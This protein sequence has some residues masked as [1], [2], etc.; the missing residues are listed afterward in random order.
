MFKN[1]GAK[2]MTLSK[3][4][5]GIYAAVGVL[6]AIAGGV[7]V[8]GIGGFFVF[9]FGAAV[10]VFVAWLSTILLYALGELCENI[11]AMREGMGY[12]APEAQPVDFGNIGQMATNFGNSV[13][14]AATNM[15]NR[16]QKSN[17]SMAASQWVCPNCGKPNAPESAF[18]TGCGCTK[19]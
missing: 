19:N 7:A 12:T 5:F 14:N 18:C 10:G 8:G 9:I 6:M 1:A 17:H 16:F 3:V 15:S 4:I 13:S 11:R 2:L